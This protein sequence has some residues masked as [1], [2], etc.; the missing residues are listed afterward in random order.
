M[1]VFLVGAKTVL[2]ASD[3]GGLDLKEIL[4][5]DL[6]RKGVSVL[7]LGT[8]GNDPVDYPDYAYELAEAFKD[9]AADMGVLLCGTGIGISIAANRYAHI[10]AALVH[11]AFGAKMARAHNDANVL[12]MGGR[13]T[14]PE[15]ARDC[16]DIFLS[17][18]FDGGRHQRRVDK[19]GAKGDKTKYAGGG[20]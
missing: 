16:L 6:E 15:I 2:I 11:D 20:D 14:G 9:G 12:V 18:P 5:A 8:H 7:D 4:K 3:H 19:M 1:K 17:T 13:V 10:R